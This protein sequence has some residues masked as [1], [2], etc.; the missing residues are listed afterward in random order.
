MP[1]FATIFELP[2]I[3]I[4][5][6]VSMNVSRNLLTVN[7]Y[8]RPG[9]QLLDVRGVVIHWVNNPGTTALNNRNYW[10]SLKSQANVKKPVYASA[11]FVIDIS[12]QIVQ[13]IPTSEVGYHAGA[14]KF[15][16]EAGER[17]DNR[18]NQHTIGIELCHPDAT[19]RF[20]QETWCAAVALAAHLCIQFNLNPRHDLWTHHGITGKICP[21]FFVDHPDAF[22]RFKLD[23][24]I[25]AGTSA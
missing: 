5:T 16:Y 1:F 10:E 15:T 21:K 23:V 4:S 19:G 11:H 2:Y 18:P 13:C 3:E 24:D 8:S 9:D 25:E 17:F 7:P 20:S 12:G 22:E 14:L 6:I